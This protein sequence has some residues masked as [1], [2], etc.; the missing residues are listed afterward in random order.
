MSVVQCINCLEME[1][2]P[3]HEVVEL[4]RRAS[5]PTTDER[6]PP[7]QPVVTA[8]RRFN[9]WYSETVGSDYFNANSEPVRSSR[10]V[11]RALPVLLTASES[12]P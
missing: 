3:V 2:V 9:Y 12:S 6:H 7:H 5:F 11:L 4:G 10:T 1:H 8:I